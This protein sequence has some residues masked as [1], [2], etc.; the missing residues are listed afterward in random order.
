[1]EN[2][3]PIF[4]AYTALGVMAVIPIYF[5]SFAAVKDAQN[6]LSILHFFTN[7]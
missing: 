4:V 2:I 7:Y 1:M 5:G 3:D 6:V